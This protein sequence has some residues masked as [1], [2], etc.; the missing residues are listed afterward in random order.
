MVRT[1]QKVV[2]NELGVLVAPPLQVSHSVG[3]N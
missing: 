2:L 1:R 3:Q